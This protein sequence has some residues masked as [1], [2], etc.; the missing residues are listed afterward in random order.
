MIPKN[1]SVVMLKVVDSNFLHRI[2]LADFYFTGIPELPASH[3]LMIQYHLI[4]E[5][6]FQGAIAF[7]ALL[8]VHQEAAYVFH[9]NLTLSC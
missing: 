5:S 9:L 2:H 3:F 1:G 7:A 8:L 4:L 6:I